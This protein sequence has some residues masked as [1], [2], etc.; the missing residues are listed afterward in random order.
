MKGVLLKDLYIAKSGI[1]IALVCL[2][3]LAFG[4]SFLLDVSSV[5][6][7]APAISTIAVY[8]SITSDASSKWNKN[9]ITMPVSRDQIIGTKYILYILLSAAGIIV[10]LAALGILSMLGAAVTVYAL[11]FNTSIG[12]S[13]ALL[14]GGIS[15]PCVYFFDPEKSQ[16]VFLVSFIASS[17]II[18][19]LVLLIN[20]FM[21]VK[22]NTLLAFYIVL[23]ISFAWFVV[24]YKIAAVL[25]RKRDIT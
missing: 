1:V 17:W 16:I 9:V 6:M 15:L 25:Y 3:V 4:F 7:L 21:P 11:L 24:S 2:F 5:L 12:V 22:D 19:A 14:A 13:A 10:V 18:T 23:A 8:N 20:L